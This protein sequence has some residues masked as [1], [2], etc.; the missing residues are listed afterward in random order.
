MLEDKKAENTKNKNMVERYLRE[1]GISSKIIA[2]PRYETILCKLSNIIRKMKLTN[3]EADAINFL[4]SIITI[5]DDGSFV[6]LEGEGPENTIVTSKYMY[7]EDDGKLKRFRVES[8]QD[9]IPNIQTISV[10]N[11]NG[12]EESLGLE[13]NIDRGKYFSKATRLPGRIDVIK[14]ERAKQEGENLEKL[15]DIYQKRAFWAALEDI[16]PEADSIDPYEIMHFNILG[17]P[18]IYVDV[19][20]EEN[21]IIQRNHGQINALSVDL[22]EKQLSDYIQNNKHY[23]RTTAFEDGIAEYLNVTVRGIEFD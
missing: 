20:E 23:G 5:D 2:N 3:R 16:E 10:Y 12:I 8:R 13:Q 15:A 22:R 9:G 1:K 18:N 7:D 21:E 19:S 14:I 11:K 17:V 4:N 6:M